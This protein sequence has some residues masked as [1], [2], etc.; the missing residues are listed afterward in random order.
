[1]GPR[2]MVS[3]E[4]ERNIPFLGLQAAFFSLKYLAENLKVAVF[5]L[6]EL[7]IWRQ[8]VVWNDERC[9]MRPLRLY[10]EKNVVLMRAAS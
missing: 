8:I 1:M 4:C 10:R 9:P 5:C 3:E 7:I 6:C 2:L